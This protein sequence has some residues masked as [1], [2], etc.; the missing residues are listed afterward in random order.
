MEQSILT[1][2]KQLL[3]FESSYTVYDLDVITQINAHFAVLQ[4]IGIGP[5][6]GFMIMDATPTWSDFF[7]EHAMNMV[8]TYVFIK[9]KLI[10]DPPASPLAITALDKQADEQFWRLAELRR[11]KDWRLYV[12]ESQQP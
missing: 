9:T 12:L 11:G 4:Q 3:G 10:F 2:T 1:S 6:N 8:K 5:E 7:T